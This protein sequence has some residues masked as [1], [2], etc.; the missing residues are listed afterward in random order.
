GIGRTPDLLLKALASGAAA[1][2]AADV[3]P[4]FS[5]EEARKLGIDYRLYD[6]R[7]LPWKD[8][9]FDA[10]WTWDVLQH[11][12][13]PGVVLRE[14][15][16][17]LSPGGLFLCRIDLRDHYHLADKNHWLDCF[18]YGESLWNAMTSNRS[19]YVNRLRLSGWKKLFAEYGFETKVLLLDED[20]SLLASREGKPLLEKLPEEDVRCWRLRAVL[21]KTG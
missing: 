5:K 12:R 9:S 11:V 7:H 15:V 13:N 21:K 20:F 16:R 18:S 4:Y 3:S 6:G 10:A 2:A 19:S 14:I 1:A 8:G 17:V